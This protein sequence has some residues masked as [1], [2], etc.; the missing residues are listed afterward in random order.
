M[1]EK[2]VLKPGQVTNWKKEIISTFPGLLRNIKPTL[3]AGPVSKKTMQSRNKK[4][5]FL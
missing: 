4:Y 2:K 5:I 1:A 3:V